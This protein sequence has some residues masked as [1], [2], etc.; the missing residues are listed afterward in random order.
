MMRMQ[1]SIALM[2]AVVALA[3]LRTRAEEGQKEREIDTEH[4]FGF[5]IGTD[6]GEVGDREL[7]S[8]LDGA[9]GKRTGAYTALAPMLGYEW[10]PVKNL[11]L[12]VTTAFSYHDISGV[13][14]LDDRQQGGFQGLSFEMRYRLLEREL[15][16]LGLTIDA[17]PHWGRFDETSGAPVDQYGADLRVLLDKD[18]IP[19]RLIGVV[20][21]IYEPEA[22]RSRITGEWTRESTLG[23]S[24][25]AMARVGSSLFV[26]VE[27][28]YLRRYDGLGL[29]QFSGHAL[30][31]GPMAFA[32]LTPN[33][34]ISGA[35]SVQVA[36]HAADDPGP[37]DLT[38]FA[39]LETRF[40]LGYNF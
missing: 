25:G 38:A 10:V 30:F 18:L 28:R 23:A 16:G 6:V 40:R 2:L 14:G 13:S 1:P 35:L 32:N 21:L 24:A 15:S 19:D 4:L 11:R 37:L 36:G 3:P 9:F 26:G 31:V 12:E 39:R 17:E 27:A 5:N 7:E 29:D 33:W 34:W 8:Q 22:A 20:N